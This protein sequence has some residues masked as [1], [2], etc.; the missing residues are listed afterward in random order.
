MYVFRQFHKSNI[1]LNGQHFSM[2]I[3]TSR[4]QFDEITFSNYSLNLFCAHQVQSTTNFAYKWK[5]R[6]KNVG[7][8]HSDQMQNNCR[9]LKRGLGKLLYT[10]RIPTRRRSGYHPNHFK[11]L[12]QQM[13]K[14]YVKSLPTCFMK[15]TRWKMLNF[16]AIKATNQLFSHAN[17]YLSIYGKK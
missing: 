8:L 14:E 2:L 7:I 17:G 16:M 9:K 1:T 6:H 13:W 12:C 10:T 4:V 3:D 5:K 15:L 11:I